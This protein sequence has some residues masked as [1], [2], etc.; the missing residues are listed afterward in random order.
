M[1]PKGFLVLLLSL[2]TCFLLGAG[3]IVYTIDP[4]FQHRSPG[5]EEL[6]LEER[7]E[8]GGIAKNASYEAVFMGTSMA[9]NYRASWFTEESGLETVKIGYRNGFLSEFDAAM[10]VVQRTHE[11]SSVIFGLDLNI[12]C[13]SEAENTVTLPGY[14]YNDTMLDDA[15]YYFSE[16]VLLRCSTL[17]KNRLMGIATPFDEAY[18]LSDYSFSKEVTMKFYQRP[19]KAEVPLD[20]FAYEAIALEN[21]AVVEAW[22]REMPDTHFTFF[23]APYSILY[24]DTQMQSGTVD[25]RFHALSLAMER[26]LAYD[27]ASVVFLMDDLDI[28]LNLNEYADYIHTSQTVNRVLVNRLLSPEECLTQETYQDVLSEFYTFVT[29][30][31]YESLFVS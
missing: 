25:A 13:R 5:N 3:A 6:F 29:S 22:L 7:Y 23:F 19:E 31:D 18:L 20:T 30:Y 11:V 21:L 1:N 26:L 10:D 27:N 24:W 8:N 17:L 4:F 14:L 9:C 28:I 16:D 2:T 15:A 12:L